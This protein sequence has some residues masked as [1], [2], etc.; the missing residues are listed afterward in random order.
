MADEY[1]PLFTDA[2][3][4][5]LRS[6]IE[7]HHSVYPKLPPQGIFFESLVERAFRQSGWPETHVILTTPNSPQH[8]LLVGTA[9]ISIKTETGIGTH[10]DLINITKLCTTEREPWDAPTLIGHVMGHLSRYDHILMLRAIWSAQRTTIHYQVIEIPMSLLHL[11][12]SVTAVA[13]GRRLGRRS[14][15]GDVYDAGERVYPPARICGQ[16]CAGLPVPH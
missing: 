16:P 1:G 12:A 13:V 11:I 2:F 5:S 8:D 9:R 10:A 4:A 3:V 7:V 15:G 6:L 14:L